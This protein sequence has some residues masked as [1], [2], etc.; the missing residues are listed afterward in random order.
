MAEIFKDGAGNPI[1]NGD[2]V[3]IGVNMQNVSYYAYGP[4][5]GQSMVDRP[6]GRIYNLKKAKGKL[7]WVGECEVML[8]SGGKQFQYT[9]NL[10]K[11]T[12]AEYRNYK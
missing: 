12:A 5:Y 2:Y 7:P 10:F 9:N 11:T 8:K 3:F 6:V 4:T 1:K